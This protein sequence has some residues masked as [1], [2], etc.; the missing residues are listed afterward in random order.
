MNADKFHAHLD[1][2]ARCR[3]K[4]FDLCPTGGALLR[5][6]ALDPETTTTTDLVDHRRR[7]HD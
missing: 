1:V 5:A 7:H 2:C 4:P 3:T 6:A